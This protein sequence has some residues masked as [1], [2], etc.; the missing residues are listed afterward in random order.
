MREPAFWVLQSCEEEHLVQLGA[1]PFKT[2]MVP[3]NPW[4]AG[5]LAIDDRF[6]ACNSDVR[7]SLGVHIPEYS[8]LGIFA[9]F[10]RYQYLMEFMPVEISDCTC[11]YSAD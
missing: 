4:V 8:P 11:N 3:E 9:V 1:G 5:A 10:D 7:R 6:K 2:E